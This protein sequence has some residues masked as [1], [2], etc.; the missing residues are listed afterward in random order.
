MEKTHTYVQDGLLT[1]WQSTDRTREWMHC[2]AGV[3]RI[4]PAK[5]KDWM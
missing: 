3:A 1:L 5:G 4:G 2:V